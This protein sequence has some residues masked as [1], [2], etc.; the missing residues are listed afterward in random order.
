MVNSVRYKLQDNK[1]HIFYSVRLEDNVCIKYTKEVVVSVP[2]GKNTFVD[3]VEK[4]QDNFWMFSIYN[5]D[6]EV[7]TRVY[8][9]PH[10]TGNLLI[11]N[12]E[13]LFD[14]R[15]NMSTGIKN[16]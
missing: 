4:Y 11:H 1:E 10:I 9:I 16:V 8:G 2:K 5:H 12:E 6:G 3:I 7:W 13:E 15:F 14:G